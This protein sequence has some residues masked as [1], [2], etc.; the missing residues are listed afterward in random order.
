MIK[1]IKIKKEV[2]EKH[3]F[4]DV[5]GVEIRIGLACSERQCSYCKRDLCEKCIG[6][7]DDDG[8]DWRVVYCKECWDIGKDYRP[9]I[10][11]LYDKIGHL[12]NEWKSRCKVE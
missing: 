5:C 2:T 9:K 4:C 10:D 8:S 1:E 3:R 11:E 6:H 12:Y 7:E